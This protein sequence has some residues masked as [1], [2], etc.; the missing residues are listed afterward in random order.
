[1]TQDEGPAPPAAPW[2]SRVRSA[3]SECIALETETLHARDALQA[4]AT[5]EWKRHCATFISSTQPILVGIADMLH[6]QGIGA[7]VRRLVQD[8][9]PALPRVA[10]LQLA[11]GR[12]AT[13]GPSRLTLRYVEGTGNILADLVVEPPGFYGSSVE[14]AL[15]FDIDR[16]S[17]E[18]VGA[19]AIELLGML[20]GREPQEA[21][22]LP[23]AAGSPFG[24]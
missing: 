24:G 16:W 23:D 2:P 1:M 7:T 8:Q 11:I 20:W 19:V 22:P 15:T 6:E 3:L 10:H 5:E 17:G 12:F 14:R 21:I 4:L 9:P 13:R 18:L